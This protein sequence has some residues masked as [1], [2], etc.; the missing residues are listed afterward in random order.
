LTDL[1]SL[2]LNATWSNKIAK[3]INEHKLLYFPM[4]ESAKDYQELKSRLESRGYDNIPSGVVPLLH[5]Q[6][7]AKAPIADVSS[8][9][10]VKTMIRR[11]KQ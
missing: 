9:K 7:Y 4:I 3:I 2:N 11:G 8:C 5:M 10:V 6:A 1:E